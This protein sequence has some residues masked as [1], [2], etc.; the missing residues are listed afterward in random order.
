M[1]VPSAT[2]ARRPDWVSADSDHPVSDIVQRLF[3]TCEAHPADDRRRDKRIAFPRLLTLKPLAEL[4]FKTVGG[5]VTVVGKSLASNGLDF[6]HCDTLPYKRVVVS[7]GDLPYAEEIHLVLNISW[8][9]FLR[10]G[11]YDSG[12]RFTHIVKLNECKTEASSYGGSD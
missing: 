8:C 6:Y 11:W 5:D 1:S 7:F 3:R 12:G 2:C 10:P 4:E 9:R